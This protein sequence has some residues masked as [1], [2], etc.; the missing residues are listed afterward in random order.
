MI[1]R[2]LLVLSLVITFTHVESPGKSV[3]FQV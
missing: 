3:T 1:L 2:R